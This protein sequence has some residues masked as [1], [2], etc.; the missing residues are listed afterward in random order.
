MKFGIER[1]R[2]K[3]KKF[4]CLPESR[5][6][7]VIL[8]VMTYPNTSRIQNIQEDG[9]IL[10]ILE[11]MSCSYQMAFTNTRAM[12]CVLTGYLISSE[13]HEFCCRPKCKVVDV[14]VPSKVENYSILSTDSDMPHKGDKPSNDWKWYPYQAKWKL[15]ILHIHRSLWCSSS[16][17]L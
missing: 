4:S 5:S 11:V 17:Y 2:S 13:A 9:N 14:D 8:E 6:M 7:L 16:H 1:G 15:A 12:E 10:N 3:L